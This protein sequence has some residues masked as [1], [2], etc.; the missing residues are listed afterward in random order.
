MGRVL[1]AHDPVLDRHVAIKL[2]REDLG[3]APDHKRQ[4]FERMRQEARA[5]ARVSHPNI[6]ALFDMGQDDV[7]GLYLVFEYVLG[8]TLKDRIMAGPLENAAAARI[9]CEL[10]DALTTAHAAGVLHRDIKPENVMLSPTG[11]KIAD[12][13][14]A[15]LPESTLTR[16]GRLLGT[17]AYSSPESIANGTFTAASDQFSL[18]STLY[19]AIS[20]TRAF[21]GD[22]AVQ[23]ATLIATTEAQPVAGR[24]GLDDLVDVVLR[25]AMQRDPNARFASCAEFGHALAAALGGS[26]PFPARSTSVISERDNARSGKALPIV[27]GAILLGALLM[28]GALHLTRGC[29]TETA[30]DPAFADA[31]T[32]YQ[33]DPKAVAAPRRHL[34]TSLSTSKSSVM[35]PAPPN[36]SSG[37]LELRRLPAD[38]NNSE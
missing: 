10:G 13:G 14:I 7:H 27:V 1:L 16:D 2:L 11:A 35:T 15:R 8:S 25:R 6:V 3:L 21:P 28:A 12:F 17:P 30:I 29:N 22:D 5:S 4:L 34:R 32:A 20:Q 26:P 37:G 33:S 24:C 23:V 36:G 19:E 31:G 9:A 18:A 38:S